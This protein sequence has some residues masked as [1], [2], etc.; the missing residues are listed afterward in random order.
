MCMNRARVGSNV[1]AR[2]T[3]RV[4][5]AFPFGFQH[6]T[7]QTADALLVAESGQGVPNSSFQMPARR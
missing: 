4:A 6:Q 3:Q 5:A 2:Q 1:P 7:G